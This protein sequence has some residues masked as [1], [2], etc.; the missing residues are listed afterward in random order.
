ML[1]TTKQNTT[2]HYT[3]PHQT[4]PH[5]T[6]LHYTTPIRIYRVACPVGPDVCIKCGSYTIINN[7]YSLN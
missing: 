6:T 3:T 5:Q 2:Q 4:T 7:F 1:S